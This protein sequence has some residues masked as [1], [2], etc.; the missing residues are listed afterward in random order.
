V[1]SSEQVQDCLRK[2]KHV[3]IGVD[4]MR[5]PKD[6]GV[7][8]RLGRVI[9]Y[10]YTDHIVLDVQV[11]LKDFQIISVSR[12]ADQPPLGSE[13]L[14]RAIKVAK[15][16]ETIAEWVTDDLTPTG[17]LVTQRRNDEGGHDKPHPQ[18]RE[19]LVFF[20]HPNERSSR[21]WCLVDLSDDT[22]REEGRVA[23]FGEDSHP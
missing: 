7:R 6:F 13:E 22:V 9:I 12:L 11:D 2:K 5:G 10:N 23:D 8:R 18:R 4:L 16:N 1:L 19:V 15:E 3:V 20:G 14:D 17:I 21:Y